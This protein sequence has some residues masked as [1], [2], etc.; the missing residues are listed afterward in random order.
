METI[1]FERTILFYKRL[2]FCLAFGLTL[3]SFLLSAD[4]LISLGIFRHALTSNNLTIQ[5]A[6]HFEIWFLRI[7]S[8][9]IPGMNFYIYFN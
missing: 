8:F 3:L 1:Q 5:K 7:I 9:Y 6:A 4:L 2:F